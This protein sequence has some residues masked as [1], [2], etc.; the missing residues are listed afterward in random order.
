MSVSNRRRWIVPWKDSRTKPAIYHCI[1]RVVDRQFV[2]EVDEREHFRMLM[3][4]CEKFTGCRVLSYCLMSNHFHILL[5]VPPMPEDGISDEELFERLGVFYSEAQVAEIAK[6][7]ADAATPRKRGEFEMAPVDEHGAPLTKAQ[8]AAMAKQQAAQRMLEIRSRYIRRMHDLSEFM[9]SLL[10]RFTKWFNRRHS[11][12][13]TLWE[14]RYK[15]VIVESGTAARMMAAYIDLNPVRA[16]MAKDPAEYRWS[17]YGEAVGGGKKGNGKKARAGL[18]RAYYCDQGV[19]MEV[20][21]WPEVSRLYRRLMGIVL[22]KKPGRASVEKPRQNITKN[23]AEVLDNTEN[24]TA[25]K[26]L[27]VAKMLRCRIRYFT[28]GAVIGGRSFVDEAFASARER[29]GPKR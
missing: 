13:G 23:S 16:G 25:L 6:E 10:E 18:V 17:S 22:G 24:E 4:M 27:G 29:F 3:R 19:G 14:E 15:S 8:V 2:M 5:E 21:K 11:R 26:E 20:E 7:M 12:S 1:S 9:K 28:D